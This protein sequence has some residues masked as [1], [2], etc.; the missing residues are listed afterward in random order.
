MNAATWQVGVVDRKVHKKSEMP[1]MAWESQGIQPNFCKTR[2]CSNQAVQQMVAATKQTAERDLA[3]AGQRDGI[4]E[5]LA[6]CLD[7]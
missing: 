5:G 2:A 7:D 6:S 3:L 1:P 4:V